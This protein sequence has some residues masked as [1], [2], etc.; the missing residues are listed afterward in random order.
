MQLI[1]FDLFVAVVDNADLGKRSD[2]LDSDSEEFDATGFSYMKEF[3]QSDDDFGGLSKSASNG[4]TNG[5]IYLGQRKK[6]K[7]FSVNLNGIR[8]F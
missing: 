6:W 2:K 3:E 5:G 8:W 1:R 4:V 7:H